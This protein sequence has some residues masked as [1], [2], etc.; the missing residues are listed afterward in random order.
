MGRSLVE[1]R[2]ISDERKPTCKMSETV[3]Q[4]WICPNMNVKAVACRTLQRR[5]GAN[6]S[7]LSLLI[8]VYVGPK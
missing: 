3:E 4:D 5:G 7:I 2:K 6:R 8:P 1:V